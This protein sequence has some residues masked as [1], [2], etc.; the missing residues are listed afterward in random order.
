VQTS[1]ERSETNFSTLR[2]LGAERWLQILFA[3][4]FL[5]SVTTPEEVYRTFFHALIY[6]LTAFLLIR[7]D[8]GAL[9]RDSFVRLFL[10]FCGYMA[11][12]TWFLGD[13]PVEDDFQASRWGLEAALGMTAFFLWMRSVVSRE[14][15][16][17][18]WFLL[19]AL[20]GALGGILS[21]VPG[22]VAGARIEGVGAMGHPIQGAS[23]AIVFLA[24]GLF[25][26]FESPRGSRR[27]D[28]LLA[29][30]SVISVCTFVTLTQ[31]RGPLISLI[32]Y[33]VFFAVLLCFQH[34]RPSTIYLFILVAASVIGMVQWLMGL[35]V[36]LDHLLAR[37]ASYRLDIWTAYLTYLPESFLFGNGAGLDF[38]LTEASRLYLE[39]MGLDISHPHNIWLGA[40]VETGLVGI[41]MQA[42]LVFLPILAVFRS[43]FLVTS[44]LHLLAILGLFLLLTFSDEYTLLT[45]LHPIW[46]FGWL[47][48][49]FV[50]TW[51]TYRQPPKNVGDVMENYREISEL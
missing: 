15:L 2:G 29:F 17:G 14:R 8:S 7:R 19:L 24:V 49:L 22:I 6:P 46:L 28:L 42:G 41:L 23:I 10:V 44:K 34:R 11:V 5:L 21:S 45:S 37:G 36:F 43:R 20:V 50:W 16:W 18:K 51:A 27:A 13:G 38:E 35:N 31:S 25:L 12:T 9:W 47:P 30:F 40:F 48:L 3:G 4:W 32:L 1:I 26:T 39:P 33:L